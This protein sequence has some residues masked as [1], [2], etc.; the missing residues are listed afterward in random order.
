[1]GVFNDNTNIDHIGHIK[2]RS[3]GAIGP[4]GRGF[5][6]TADGNYDMDGK[7]L[8]NAQGPVDDS[9]LTNKLYVDTEDA[10]QDT[11]INDNSQKIGNTLRLDGSKPMTGDLDMGDNKVI[12]LK[13]PTGDQDSVTKNTWKNM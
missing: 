9:D 3:E 5:K 2:I 13:D 4:P 12:N 7:S 6:L 11:A 8:T 1:M 10:K